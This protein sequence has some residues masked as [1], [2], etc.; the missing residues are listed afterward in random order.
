MY[1]LENIENG[2]AK[3]RDGFMMAAA[4]YEDIRCELPNLNPMEIPKMMEQ[5]PMPEI[6]ELSKSLQQ[7]LTKTSDKTVVKKFIQ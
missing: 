1:N 7:L 5:V 6:N 2:L 3:V 4:R